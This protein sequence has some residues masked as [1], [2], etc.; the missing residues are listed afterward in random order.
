M[1]IFLAGATGV[2]G[3]RLAPLLIA[4]GHEVTGMTRSPGKA[5]RLRMLGAEP[6]ICDALDPDAVHRTVM[7]AAPELIID[8]LTDLPDDPARIGDHRQAHNRIRREGVRNLLAAAAL[9][10]A[11]AISQSIAWTLDDDD[12][13][14]AV[15]EHEQLVLDAGGVIVRYGQLYGPGTFYP[16]QPPAPPRIHVDDAARRT[17]DALDAPGGTIITFVD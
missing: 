8:Q 6:V 16:R 13:Q 5:D 3:T 17:A 9:L 15:D 4:Q 1:R 14:A 10:P 11:R 7:A 12:A 2:I